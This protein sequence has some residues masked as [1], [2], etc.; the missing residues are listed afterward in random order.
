M[1]ITFTPAYSPA[2]FS[3]LIISSGALACVAGGYLSQKG[4]EKTLARFFLTT[5]ASCCIISPLIFITGNE[6]MVILFLFVWGMVV[7]ADSPLFS[8]LV[9]KNAPQESK[10]TA[11]TIVNCLGFALTI[12]SIQFLTY[13]STILPQAYLF[14]GLAIGP[15]LGLIGLFQKNKS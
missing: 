15:L 7:I 9:A 10:G 11:L 8:T 13:T 12:L 3:F 5:S 2:L 6:E 14:V 1:L 4:A